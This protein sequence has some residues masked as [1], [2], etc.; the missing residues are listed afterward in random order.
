MPR[1]KDVAVC[2]RHVEFS[3]TSQVVV[4]L[5]AEH[6]KVRGLAKGSRRLAPSSIQRFS[7]GFELLTLGQVVATSRPSSELASLTEWDLRDD[8]HHL[9]QNWRAQRLAF[10][11]GDLTHALLADL[12]PHPATFGAFVALLA[13]LNDTNPTNQ[14]A[15][16]LAFQWALLDDVGYRPVL[17]RDALDDTPLAPAEAY[18]FNPQAGGFTADAGTSPWRVRRATLDALRLTRDGRSQDAE[19]QAVHRAN[20]LLAAYAREL[21]G[22]ELPTLAVALGA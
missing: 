12:D 10:Y 6:G 21:I 3:E 2:L 13:G 22:R 14:D 19:A 4:L 9:R 11:A 18:T 7:G 20:R 17:D 16:L 1:F 8:V 5:T 15:A